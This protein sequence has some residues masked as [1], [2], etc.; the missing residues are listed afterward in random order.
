[1]QCPKCQAKIDENTIFCGNCGQQVAP[2]QARGATVS[3]ASDE[4]TASLEVNV[5]STPASHAPSTLPASYM[6]G[7]SETPA[8]AGNA[9][10][11]ASRRSRPGLLWPAVFLLVLL[12]GGTVLAIG[13]L[14]HSRGPDA[15]P[16]AGGASGQVIFIDGTSGSGGTDALRISI[17]GL[18]APPAGSHYD[19][20]LV[21][22]ASERTAAL[23]QLS[24][25][26]GGF[27]LS[28]AGNGANG[29]P[30]VN[31]LSSGNIVKITQEQSRVQL[32]T[33]KV[34]LSAQFPPAAFVHIKHLLFSFPTT[35][36]KK[37]LLVGLLEQTRLLNAQALALQSIAGSQN[38]VAIR[39]LAQS[40]LDISEGLAGPHAHVL[41]AAC[42]ASTPTGDGFG[43]LGTNGY[44]S[45]AATHA[46][47]AATQ[48]DST[49]TI[50][51]HAGEVETGTT[52]ISHW[53]TTL[54]QDALALL[55]NP[56]NQARIAEIVALADHAFHGVDANGNGQIEPVAQ[57]EGAATA[58][59]R[60][61]LMASLTLLP[62]AK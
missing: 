1:M 40:L 47:L 53:V 60:A 41:P 37:G 7:Q 11:F 34:L 58:Y 8:P 28:F 23:G 15:N 57:E 59:L 30:G 51:L 13:L 31:L 9:G 21:D 48:A 19:A 42:G 32:P 17:N 12:A 46:S 4:K 20:W 6:R 56:A 43:I 62:P 49:T 24:A 5:R 52:N 55:S 29:R 3:Y 10:G 16:L 50:R 61:Q 35:P 44:A 2:F 39:C 25:Q 38:I 54:D 27:T 14:R 26:G 22:E 45:T 33:G 18:S 36:G